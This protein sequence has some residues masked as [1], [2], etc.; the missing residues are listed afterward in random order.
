LGKL[1]FFFD[2]NIGVKL[3]QALLHL[4]P[5]F[6]VK[7]HA[8]EGFQHDLPDDEWLAIVGQKGWI[9]VGQDWKFHIRDSEIL[10]VKQ[11]SI[12]CFYLPASGA[13]KWET[14]CRVIKSHSKML[15]VARKE[16]APFIF[17]L[18]SNGRLVK[19]KL[20]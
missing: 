6:Q 20:P 2:R 9:V 14:F 12:K 17:D 8:Q 11:H 19:V 16:T 15:E 18:K 13:T 1:T 10:A 7:W 4:A 5:P 3:P